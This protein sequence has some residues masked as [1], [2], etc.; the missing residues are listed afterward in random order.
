[1][2]SMLFQFCDVVGHNLRVAH[3]DI[4]YCV[5]VSCMREEHYNCFSVI[6]H[7]FLLFCATAAGYRHEQADDGCDNTSD[8][9]FN[10]LL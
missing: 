8:V 3:L 2:Y 9:H 10:L 7:I 6:I 1:M 5:V 4:S